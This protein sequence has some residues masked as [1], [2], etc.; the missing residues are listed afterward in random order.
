MSIARK[1]I[2]ILE[3]IDPKLQMKND[4]FVI[5]FNRDKKADALKALKKLD[6]YMVI[7]P[8]GNPARA[9]I[10]TSK[11]SLKDI[12]AVDGVKHAVAAHHRDFG[13]E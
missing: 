11:L 12:E 5:A 3:G 7:D 4:N 13:V 6:P 9:W 2:F 10:Q 1:I 8:E